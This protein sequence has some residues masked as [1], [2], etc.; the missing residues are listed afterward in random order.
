MKSVRLVIASIVAIAVL[1]FALQA[2]RND[3]PG[4]HVQWVANA[5]KEMQ[6]I[7]VGMTRRDLLRVFTTEGGLSTPASRQYV[8]RKCPYFKVQV[9]FELSDGKTTESPDDKIIN[10]SKPY[11]EAS[12]SD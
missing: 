6:T 9:E 3:D 10:L 11:L 4:G 12:I 2:Q 8:Y 1:S 5:M 7:K